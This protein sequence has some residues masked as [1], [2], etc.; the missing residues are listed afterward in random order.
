MACACNKRRPAAPVYG[1]NASKTADPAQLTRKPTVQEQPVLVKFPD[2]TV[3]EYL[4]K[5]E[6]HAARII[7]GGGEFIS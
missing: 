7:A 4:S 1:R 6:A 3:R 2:G 5:I